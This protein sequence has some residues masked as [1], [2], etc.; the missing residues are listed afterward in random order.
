VR[1][2]GIVL[3]AGAGRRFGRPKADVVLD[4]ERLVQRAVRVALAGGCD[5]VLAVVRA[6]CAPVDGAGLIVNPDPDRGMGSS[7]QIAMAALV[8][9]AG[10]DSAELDPVADVALVQLVD[11]PGITPAAVTRVLAA[12]DAQP[13]SPIV[14][15]MYDGRRGHPVSFRAAIWAEIIRHA[16][17]DSGARTLMAKHPEWVAEIEC[18]DV[19]D[20]RDI[21]TPEDLAAIADM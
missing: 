12:A 10:N 20:A 21:D 18:A 6:G 16:Q 5:R 13:G 1:A 3:A 11:M 17:G 7:L 9:M 15:A 4:G 2:V 14:A 19:A 8:S